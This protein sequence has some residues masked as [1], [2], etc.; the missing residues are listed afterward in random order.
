MGDVTREMTIVLFDGR[1][2][3]LDISTAD[4]RLGNELEAWALLPPADARPSRPD[5]PPLW[6]ES[7]RAGPLAGAVFDGLAPDSPAWAV[8]PVAAAFLSTATSGDAVPDAVA[9]AIEVRDR[10]ARLVNL[11]VDHVRVT[12]TEPLDGGGW[13]VGCEVPDDKA[14]RTV[15]VTLNRTGSAALIERSRHPRVFICYAHD[16]PAHIHLVREFAEFLRIAGID[17]HLDRWYEGGRQDWQRWMTIQILAA[18]F[19]IVIA[20]PVCKLVGDGRNRPDERRGLWAEMNLLRE[21]YLAPSGAWPSRMLPVVLPGSSVDD[22]PLFLQPRAA[23]HYVLDEVSTVAADRLL[24]HLTGQQPY[25]KP[26]LGPLPPLSPHPP[27]YTG[28]QITVE[29]GAIEV[30]P[31]HATLIDAWLVRQEQQCRT[32]PVADPLQALATIVG[33]GLSLIAD[34]RNQLDGLPTGPGR[35][36]PAAVRRFGVEAVRL[37]WQRFSQIPRVL[38]GTADPNRRPYEEEVDRYLQAS[39]EVLEQRARIT[40][41][42]WSGCALQLRLVNPRTADLPAVVVRLTF[43]DTVRPIEPGLADTPLPGLPPRPTR[44]DADASP[45][46]V[47]HDVA[48]QDVALVRL[49][50][51]ASHGRPA[52]TDY[53]IVDP[54]QRA[55][56]IRVGDLPRKSSAPLPAI[57][58]LVS[59]PI[60][61]DVVVRWTTTADGE[62]CS[63]DLTLSVVASAMPLDG[64]LG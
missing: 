22:I 61:A 34:T 47:L 11:P 35:I 58:L 29:R 51:D 45:T 14:D 5:E 18:D 32:S 1:Q 60:G 28:P 40:T 56:E 59:G 15:M 52:Q 17:A 36:D 30:T 42:Q 55:V 33:D 9:A 3:M 41:A 62:E 46:I 50:T 8:F 39:R 26:P 20:S 10:V 31:D 19:V 12:A 27:A 38:S 4:D 25:D 6:I 7:L 57:P 23:D 48:D 21:L 54:D 16:S 13:R 37:S 44:V 43:P 49:L 24:R 63:G 64:L 2:L 53:A